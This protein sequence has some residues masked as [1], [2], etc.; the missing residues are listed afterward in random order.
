MTIEIFEPND[1]MTRFVFNRRDYRRNPLGL[2]SRALEPAAD[3]LTTSVTQTTNIT[4][5]EIW[6][7]GNDQLELRQ[8]PNLHGRGDFL[9][10]A[11]RENDL[12]VV[13]DPTPEDKLHANIVNW[14]KDK[15]HRMHLAREIADSAEFL[16]N[17]EYLL[18]N[19]QISHE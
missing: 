2:K 5:P 12:D 11:I 1:R 14:P 19:P 8:N 16:Y 15:E 4:D 18:N 10:E 9:T 3:S 17:P 6:R 13:P 7:K